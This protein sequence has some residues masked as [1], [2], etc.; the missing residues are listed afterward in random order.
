MNL[1]FLDL[2]TAFGQSLLFAFIGVLP[3]LNPL[4][5]APPVCGPGA[6]LE[7][8]GAGHAGPPHWEKRG[9]FAGRHHADRVVCVAVF[10]CLFARGAHCRGGDRG[11]DCLAHAQ[12]P[13]GHH[14]R[15][16]TNGPGPDRGQGPRQSLLP[17]DVSAHLRAGHHFGG[18]CRGGQLAFA[19]QHPDVFGEFV[20][21]S[22]GPPCC[23]ACWWR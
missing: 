14:R 4:A 11:L 13:A 8:P 5:T 21:W 10:W 20:R 2:L 16:H 9:H 12:R 7:R 22:G 17:P 1:P 15:C 6:R 23:W 19:H 18:H 3:I